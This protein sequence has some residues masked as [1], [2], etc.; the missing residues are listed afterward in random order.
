M[1][2]DSREVGV[3]AVLSFWTA[4]G[5]G[6]STSELI[7]HQVPVFQ[8]VSVLPCVCP[9][10]FLTCQLGHVTSSPCLLTY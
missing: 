7:A 4:A 2:P 3:G 9:P 5:V 6:V 8:N 1:A 10:L